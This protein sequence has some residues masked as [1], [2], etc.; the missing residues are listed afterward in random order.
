MSHL[1][2]RTRVHA[3]LFALLLLPTDA[4]ASTRFR[5]LTLRRSDPAAE[6]R[7]SASPARIS[8]WFT[9]KPQVAFSRMRLIGPSGA[10]PLGA[11]VADTGNAFHAPVGRTLE[12][13]AY[14]LEWQTASADGHPISGQFAFM[15]LGTATSTPVTPVDTGSHTSHD[16]AANATTRDDSG[17]RT[18]RWLEF[19]AVLTVL[20]VLG[21][22]HGVLPPLAARGVPTA[23]AADRARRLG[24]SVLALYAVAV[25]VRLYTQSRVLNGPEA[26]LDANGI[27]LLLGSSTWG[28]GWTAGVIGAVLLL[29]GWSVSKRSVTIGT[30]LAL[31]GALGMVLSPALSGHSASSSR[32]IVSVTLD[33]LHVTAAGIWVGALA[34]VLFA[35]IPAMLRLTEGNKHAAVSALVN[36]FHPL[37]LFCAPL[38]V[39]SGLGASWLRM[40]G[41]GHQWSTLYGQTL[42]LK[43]AFVGIVAGMGTYNSLRVRRQL[44]G[45]GDEGTRRFRVTGSIE[46]AFAAVVVIVTTFLV[47]TPLPNEMQMP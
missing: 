19:V 8:L 16:R 38:T 27:R 2:G 11:I 6:S 7:L 17:F 23:D 32:F 28:I 45:A 10:V 36:S 29:I 43:I 26:A 14:R 47:V 18:A 1:A 41:F 44:I 4:G 15:V 21:F 37:A 31:T 25:L 9:A 42:L 35:G 22:R 46:L 30:P 12:P 34:M 39:L 3:S 13:G 40:G 20:G 33:M 5:H 24:L